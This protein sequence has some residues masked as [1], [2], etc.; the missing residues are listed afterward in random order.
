MQLIS[1][2]IFPPN[3]DNIRTKTRPQ[4][5]EL[6]PLAKIDKRERT[7]ASANQWKYRKSLKRFVTLLSRDCYSPVCF[8][9]GDNKKTRNSLWNDISAKRSL[10]RGNLRAILCPSTSKN[11]L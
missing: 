3:H 4:H 5:R 1:P 7:V 11:I 8:E 6:R 9:V 2:S 10:I